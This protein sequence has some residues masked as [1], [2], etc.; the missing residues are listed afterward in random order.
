M[1]IPRS[2]EFFCKGFLYSNPRLEK[3]EAVWQPLLGK[4]KLKASVGG[5]IKDRPAWS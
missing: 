5:S 3:A 2:G 1:R 4:A